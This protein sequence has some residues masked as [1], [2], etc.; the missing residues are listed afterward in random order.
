VLARNKGAAM[1]ALLGQSDARTAEGAGDNEV[2]RLERIA[3]D[4]LKQRGVKDADKAPMP[5]EL[6]QAQ[7]ERRVRLG[8]VVA[9]LVRP[10]PAGQAGSVA[11]AHRGDE[12][13]LREAGRGG[14][15]VPERPQAHGRSRGV[16]V[17]NNV[18]DFVL[19]QAKV[20]ATSARV[21][22]PDEQLKAR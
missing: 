20:T 4:D 5:Q 1:D 22:R 16:V 9:E 18:T 21:R 6:F 3:R 14:A 19:A 7:A 12:P 13:E 17:E 11:G 2:E 15:L 8:L 10:Q